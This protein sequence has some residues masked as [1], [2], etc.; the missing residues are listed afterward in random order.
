MSVR[1]PMKVMPMRIRPRK[2]PR[3]KLSMTYL[4]SK[5]RR[6]A[7]P[8]LSMVAVLAVFGCSTV[9]APAGR[10][11]AGTLPAARRAEADSLL[12]LAQAALDQEAFELAEALAIVPRIGAIL[13]T[14]GSPG[15]RQFA[16][17]IQEGIEV[18]F[19]MFGQPVGNR[20]AAE[21]VIQDS[22][23]DLVGARIAFSAIEASEVLG[24]IGP[25]QDGALSEI[26][27]RVQGT[28]AVISPTSSIVP[29]GSTGV[30][31]LSSADPGGARALARYAMSS[32][33]F[34]AVVLYPESADGLYEA[35]A[36][37]E[38]FQSYGGLMLGE[39]NYPTGATFFEEQLRQAEALLPDVLV[40]PLPARDVELMAPQVTFFGLDS[41]EIRVL[42][43]TGWSEEA[44]LSRVDTRHTNGVVTVSP[45]L[46]EGR[47]EGYERFVE[48]YE[49]LYQRTLPDLLPALGF[50]AAGLL[51][52]GIRRGAS[53]PDAL[54]DTLEAM[55]GFSGATGRLFVDDGR[56]VRDHFVGCLQDR[57]VLNVADGARA[58][59]IV[60]PPL[61]DPET[62]SIPEGA[63][64]R[65]VGFRCPMLVPS[66]R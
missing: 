6:S 21:L 23:G 45:Q 52:E 50:D 63:L 28:L 5:V 2:R 36:F 18:A 55:R 38:A 65:V 62:D 7:A 35:R 47:P 1:T 3:A 12:A 60:R 16:T 61:R 56:V 46:A 13:P 49:T 34:T 53:T 51:L 24:V 27:G 37:S 11:E 48:A 59:P 41:L 30:Y 33:L 8:V 42:G 4:P 39:I 58:E 32:D 31:S 19:Q 25:L 57:R 43:T 20:T 54:L 40:L 14:S 9:G 22:G 44:M 64:D 66:N 10:T 26:A 17:G 15:M 29:E